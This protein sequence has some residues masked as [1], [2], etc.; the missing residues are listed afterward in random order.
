MSASWRLRKSRHQA[1][2]RTPIAPP[3]APP[4]QVRPE[5][6]KKFPNTLPSRVSPFSISQ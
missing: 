4:Y 5:P 3:I 6:E 1:Q 2:S